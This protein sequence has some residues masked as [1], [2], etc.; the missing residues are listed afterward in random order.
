MI[1][2]QENKQQNTITHKAT[3]NKKTINT[4]TC[5][6]H[7]TEAKNKRHKQRGTQHD[8]THKQLQE[9]HTTI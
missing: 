8:S 4:H 9:S 5:H 1:N 6:T 3:T 2:A 7:T